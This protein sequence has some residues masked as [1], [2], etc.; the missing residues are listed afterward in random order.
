MAEFTAPVTGLTSGRTYYVRAFAVNADG[1]GYGEDVEFTTDVVG[2]GAVA[3]GVRLAGDGETLDPQIALAGAVTLG[4]VTLDGEGTVG[5]SMVGT[6]TL[7]AVSVFGAAYTDEGI[8]GSGA[9]A[10][11]ASVRGRGWV[12]NHKRLA[13]AD[14]IIARYARIYHH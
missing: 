8:E 12:Y 13:K 6:A 4:A 14:D 5:F 3:A 11:S 7:G 9:C 10:A 1:V 2:T